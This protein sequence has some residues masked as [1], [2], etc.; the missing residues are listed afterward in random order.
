MY[1]SGMKLTPNSSVGMASCCVYY[2]AAYWYGNSHRHNTSISIS[3]RFFTGIHGSRLIYSDHTHK[4][5]HTRAHARTH[6][7]VQ[8]FNRYTGSSRVFTDSRL[9]YSDHTHTHARTHARTLFEAKMSVKVS[10][11][12][13]SND[14]AMINSFNTEIGLPYTSFGAFHS[15]L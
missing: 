10:F 1:I 3:Y 2:S 6:I 14:S 8:C 4:H 11:S 12:M 15:C 7:I 13:T 5:K 9:I